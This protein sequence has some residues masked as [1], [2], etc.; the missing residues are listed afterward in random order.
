MHVFVIGATGELGRPAVREMVTAGH[1]VRAVARTQA[2]AALL[3]SLGTEPV[4]VPDVFERDAVAR[5]ARGSDALLHLATHIP[6]VREM[7]KAAAW[8]ENN[9]LRSQ[10][11]PMLVDMAVDLGIERL[12]AESVTFVYPDCGSDWISETTPLAA[13]NTSLRSVLDLER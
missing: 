7:W 6:P 13:D 8:A 3:S 9:R 5:A 2:K 4:V 11:T 12:V 1:R 10:L